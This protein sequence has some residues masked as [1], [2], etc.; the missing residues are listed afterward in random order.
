MKVKYKAGSIYS[1]LT[2]FPYR[3]ADYVTIVVRYWTCK[4][5]EDDIY[6]HGHITEVDEVRDG[7]WARLDDDPVNED[8]FYYGDIEAVI[9]GGVVAI[10]EVGSDAEH[11]RGHLFPPRNAVWI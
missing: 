4:E 9:D 6:Y 10:I 11:V 7:F 5:N 2:D 1:D 8:F 3:E